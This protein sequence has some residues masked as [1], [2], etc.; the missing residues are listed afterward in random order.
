VFAIVRQGNCSQ[1]PPM[2]RLQLIERLQPGDEVLWL[3][4]VESETA[5]GGNNRQGWSSAP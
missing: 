3:P 2:R 1:L 4:G 5:V